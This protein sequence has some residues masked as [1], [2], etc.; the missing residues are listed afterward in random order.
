MSERGPLG[1]L[2]GVP[3]VRGAL[4]RAAETRGCDALIAAPEVM[5]DQVSGAIGRPH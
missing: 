3:G 2:A 4:A 5:I 1:A